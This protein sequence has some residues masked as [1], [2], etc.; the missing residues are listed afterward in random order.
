METLNFQEIKDTLPISNVKVIS[1]SM[2]CYRASVT[3]LE[4]MFYV[5][6]VGTFEFEYYENS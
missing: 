3:L 4:S 2:Q 1:R 6:A 5:N